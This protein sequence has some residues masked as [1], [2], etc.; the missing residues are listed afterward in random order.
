[1]SQSV[2][3]AF[4]PLV[5]LDSEIVWISALH[6]LA[7]KIKVGFPDGF[8]RQVRRRFRRTAF[9]LRLALISACMLF[10]SRL[11]RGRSKN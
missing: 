5:P 9:W 3:D 10:E 2:H 4:D 8:H 7:L 11:Q 6:R 1:M